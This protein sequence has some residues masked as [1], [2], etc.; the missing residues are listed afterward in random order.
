MRIVIIG[1]GVAA[2]EAAVSAR[3]Q[4]PEAAVALL[5]REQLP[6][7]RRP[8]LSG[9]VAEMIG[10]DR[11]LIQKPAFYPEQRIDLK[12]G[13]TIT[14]IDRAHHRLIAADGSTTAYDK[15]VIATG[16]RGVLPPV[17]GLDSAGALILREYADLLEIRRRL[18][19]GTIRRAAVIGGGVL[20]LELAQSLLTRGAA[21]TVIEHSPTLLP[22]NLDSEGAALVTGQLSKTP[23]LT[24]I[25]GDA[26][27]AADATGLQLASGRRVEADLIMVSAGVCPN[28]ELAS[29]AGLPVGRGIQTDSGLRTTDP[30]IFAAGDVVE[31]VCGGGLYLTARAMGETAGV[32]AAGSSAIFTAA[33]AAVRLAALGVKLFS[34][35]CLNG[36][37]EGG[38]DA[39]TGNYR[40]LFRDDA[41]R[42]RGAILIGNVAEGNRLLSELTTVQ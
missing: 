24:L 28:A 21:V 31:A 16:G 32:N 6:P 11:L 38:L 4:A 7:Y 42:L 27:T 23:G 39:A 15:L 40:K 20:G 2:F 14:A 8:A 41:G 36:R 12:L 37:A 9:M 34:A 25:F 22:R 13:V 29:A 3:R 17:P 33:P 10:D 30:D 18:D 19:T 26:I 1:G 35:G 5:S